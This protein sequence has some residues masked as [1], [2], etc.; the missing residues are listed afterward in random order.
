MDIKHVPLL[1]QLIQEAIAIENKIKVMALE[2]AKIEGLDKHEKLN[3]PN[4]TYYKN[5]EAYALYKCSYYLC[6][7]CKEPYFG[8]LKDCDAG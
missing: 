2:R 6:F 3:D 4:Y 5:L 7:K 1:D 8:G